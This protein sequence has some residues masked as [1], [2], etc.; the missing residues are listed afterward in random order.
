MNYVTT[1]QTSSFNKPTTP[2]QNGITQ[3]TPNKQN[4]MDHNSQAPSSCR[5]KWFAFSPTFLHMK[6]H[7]IIMM[8]LI[9]KLSTVKI[10]HKATH[11][12][13]ESQHWQN[14]NSPYASPR[15]MLIHPPQDSI[16]AL[17]LESL[18]FKLN[19]YYL[20]RVLVY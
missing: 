12:Q 4:N 13:K 8:H 10:L 20:I 3:E 2:V 9:H 17:H 16:I 5:Y 15:K 19:F 14:P 18:E 1:C 11:P 6:R 7:S